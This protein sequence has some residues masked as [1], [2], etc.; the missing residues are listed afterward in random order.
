MVVYTAQKNT[1]TY[2]DA[3]LLPANM[4]EDNGTDLASFITAYDLPDYP[5]S[6]VFIDKSVDIAFSIGQASSSV[7]MDSDHFP[8]GYRESVPINIYVLDKTGITGILLLEKVEA[9]LRRIM[10]T[11][12]TA[13]PGSLRRVSKTTPK[14]VLVGGTYFWVIEYAMDY[15]RDKT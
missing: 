7:I 10:E 15:V 12:P 3:Y 14:S 5:L 8:L 2:L 4:T 11:Y 13:L 9:E 1:K 6:R